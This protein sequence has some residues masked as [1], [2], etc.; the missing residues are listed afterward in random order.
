MRIPLCGTYVG[1]NVRELGKR[2]AACIHLPMHNGLEPHHLILFSENGVI[3][4]VIEAN[5]VRVMHPPVD[6]RKPILGLS[7]QL[8]L[9]GSQPDPSLQSAY[10]AHL[11]LKE[12]VIGVIN[13]D[14][15]LLELL[16]VAQPI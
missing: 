8:G 15:L 7:A 2:A 6:H 10:H 16:E 4:D 11:V 5:F 9:L 1:P 3:I 12:L 14:F 13:P